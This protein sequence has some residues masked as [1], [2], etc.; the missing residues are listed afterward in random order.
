MDEQT[1][2]N[3]YQAYSTGQMSPQEA[4][5]YEADVQSGA[6]AVPT[7]ASL[8][9]AKQAP[10]AT[11][12]PSAQPTAQ[13]AQQEIP[14]Q[15]F[16][17]YFT[18]QMS[19]QEMKEFEADAG[20][21]VFKLPEG[22]TVVSYDT[23][24]E[25]GFQLKQE[26]DIGDIATG[27]GEAALTLGTGA[28]TG[29]A[30]WIGGVLK[31][32]AENIR[33]GKYGTEE[34]AQLVEK[35]AADLMQQFTYTPRTE[36]GQEYVETAAKVMEPL[37]AMGPAAMELERLGAAARVKPA[38]RPGVAAREA[39]QVAERAGI[40]PITSDIFPP[41]TFAGRL[42]QAAGE[43]I[44]VVGTGPLRAAQQET[45]RGAIKSFLSEHGAVGAEN[46][47]DDV[48]SS[49]SK[50]RTDKIN[51]YST[52]K[53]DVFAKMPTAEVAVAKTVSAIDDEVARLK[54]MKT[55]GVEPLINVLDDYKEA[56]KNQDIANIEALRKQLGDQLDSP[57]LVSAA[58]E[59]GKA[60]KKVYKALN[61]DIGNFIK[62][63]GEKRDFDKWMVANKQLS[64]MFGEL[65]N[66]TLKS[67]LRRGDARPEVVKSMLFSKNASDIKALYKNLTKEGRENARA[68]I[69]HEALE[70][71]GG[72]EDFTPE[73]FTS[74]M[75][76]LQK[77]TGIFFT[78]EDRK[79]LDGLQKALKITKQASV[80]GVKPA[81]GAELTAFAT[82]TA[83]T[84]L[85]GSDPVTGLAATAGVGG[86]ARL[87]ESKAVRNLLIKLANAPKAKE[88]P[89][90]A[91]L[92]TAIQAQKT[93]SEEIK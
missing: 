30:A 2:A 77:S 54:S 25:Q 52:M 17:A 12:Q 27:L 18:N 55:K 5:E 38:V 60:S 21:G 41:K 75:K 68:A 72:I 90:T 15:V 44:P 16:E 74:N 64:S 10:T 9:Q 24:V 32:L 86:M 46:V 20:T 42:T 71:A 61:E 29:S 87:Y 14:T 22:T 57:D 65:E 88:V 92:V 6:I 84:W 39:V 63:N 69:L 13:Q 79:A 53:Q 85:L 56:F 23:G 83:L 45:R 33:S 35:T 8:A 19:P 37:A 66:S 51:K 48:M 70:K 1:L 11:P 3:I 36:A 73:K 7:G 91:S 26:R 4:A 31:G 76:R 67:T 28:T 58:T 47:L 82:P 59:S 78:G 62:L 80:A 50:S 81:T 89:L 43:R 49:L 34:G 93:K 40:T